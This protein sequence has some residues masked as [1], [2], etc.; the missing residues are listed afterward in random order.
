[1]PLVVSALLAGACAVQSV[2]AGAAQTTA[3]FQISEKPSALL[4][5][6]CIDC[7]ED[8]TEKGGIRLDNLGELTLNARL[9]LMNKMQEQVTT[10]T[11]AS[12]RASS[13]TPGAWARST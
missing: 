9:D 7:H 3:P 12:P 5:K 8:G 11:S 10:P 2:T 1:M 13:A 4:E 6:Y